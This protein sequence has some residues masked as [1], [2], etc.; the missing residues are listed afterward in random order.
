MAAGKNIPRPPRLANMSK[1]VQTAAIK[2]GSPGQNRQPLT[3]A[4]MGDGS[5][6]AV[7]DHTGSGRRTRLPTARLLLRITVLPFI[8]TWRSSNL[9][10]TYRTCSF[11][12]RSSIL[13][14]CDA[15]GDTTVSTGLLRSVCLPAV[16]CGLRERAYCWSSGVRR[17]VCQS[18]AG[19]RQLVFRT[20]A[21]GSRLLF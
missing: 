2:Q 20:R 10:Q 13:M 11:D 8:I 12:P 21:L 7:R 5:M 15:V 3:P 14:F 19:S 4:D 6:S 9:N 16:L 18:C 17:G 1:G